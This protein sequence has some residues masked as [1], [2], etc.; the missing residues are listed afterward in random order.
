MSKPVTKVAGCTVP[1]D[2]KGDALLK[3]MKDNLNTLIAEKKSAIKHSDAI[4]VTA[5]INSRLVVGKDGTLQKAAADYQP[6]MS[7]AQTVLVVINTTNWFDSHSDVHIPGI[8]KKSI[9]ET[10]FFSHLQ[11]HQQM[12]THIISDQSKGYTEKMAWK[13]LGYD[14]IGST[15]AL[16]F[17]TPFTGRN[18]YM[19]DQYRKGYVKNH[20]VGMRYVTLKF[21]VNRPDDEYYKEEYANWVQY[22]EQ[23]INSDAAEE[24]GYF[25]AVL[26]A[27]IVE[28]SAVPVGSNIITPTLG[29]KSAQPAPTT[30]K[31]QPS[32]D[33][34]VKEEKTQVEVANKEIDWEKISKALSN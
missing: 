12:F 24:Q 32:S 15:E 13:E 19:E 10:K 33:T 27:K 25:W 6:D 4:M 9:K 22:I 7:T 30:E 5:D 29:F 21:C 2:L 1:A 14:A 31:I 23:V 28:G 16:I 3:W 18:A 34:E 11:E 20:S 8:W 26:E 17:Q